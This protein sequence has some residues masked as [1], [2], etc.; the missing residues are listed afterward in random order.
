MACWHI[1]AKIDGELDADRRA[2]VPMQGGGLKGRAKRPD[3][4]DAMPKA[5]GRGS[6]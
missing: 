1:D 2:G 5:C 4:P 6:A 3:V